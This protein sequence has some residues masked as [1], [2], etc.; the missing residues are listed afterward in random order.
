VARVKPF[1]LVE[2]IIEHDPEVM[3]ASISATAT[4]VKPSTK[5][6]KRVWLV[7]GIEPKGSVDWVTEAGAGGRVV[8]LMEALYDKELESTMDLL[9]AMTD[10]QVREYLAE[11]RPELK[12]QEAP[13]EPVAPTTGAELT[14]EQITGLLQRTEVQDFLRG[15]TE[16]A[17]EDALAEQG[18]R[19]AAETRQHSD[20][21]IRIRE[22][23]EDAHT[24]ID[25]SKLP[26]PIRVELKRRFDIQ[27]NGEAT[28]ALDVV[29]ELEDERVVKTDREVL[30]ESVEE[31]IK[32]QRELVASLS[33][34]R[35]TGQGAVTDPDKPRERTLA[36]SYAG[37]FLQEA[38]INADEAY[39]LKKLE[40]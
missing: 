35:V 38:G 1:G 9:E 33:P 6:G 21:Q 17:V 12:L 28:A 18:P 11:H 32:H 30:R 8:S 26:E 31:E 7:E 23:R 34:T 37:Q 14:D 22:L 3:E 24:Q 27:E 10:D 29:A 5:D 2:Q 15:M 40:D 16:A 4:G 25:G 36:G 19:I 39:G 20:R 13:A